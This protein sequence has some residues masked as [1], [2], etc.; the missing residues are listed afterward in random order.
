MRSFTTRSMPMMMSIAT[1]L[2]AAAPAFAQQDL[3]SDLK[4]AYREPDSQIEFRN[5]SRW[6]IE[7]LFFA[8]VGS[9]HWGPNQISHAPMRSGDRFTLTSIRCDKYDVKIIDEDDNE[10]VVRDVALCGDEKVWRLGDRD[11]LKCQSRTRQ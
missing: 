2:L 10:C 8:P 3:K 1:A 11:L 7:Q 6:S 9:D 4:P 5:D